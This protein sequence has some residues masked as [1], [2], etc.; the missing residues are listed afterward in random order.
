MII[1]IAGLR[2]CYD[3]TQA[4]F[5]AYRQRRGTVSDEGGN[6]PPGNEHNFPGESQSPRD[7]NSPPRR[8]VPSGNR[9]PFSFSGWAL[10]MSIVEI[11]HIIYYVASNVPERRVKGEV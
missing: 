10:G 4:L 5:F 9:P 7:S 6:R 2:F 1:P 8:T 3:K 11:G